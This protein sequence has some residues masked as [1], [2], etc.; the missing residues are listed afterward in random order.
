MARNRDANKK[1]TAAEGARA[2]TPERGRAAAGRPEEAMAQTISD[3]EE[4]GGALP[5][6]TP[7]ARRTGGHRDR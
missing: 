7:R 5:D 2:R 6:P 3:W 1:E 4:E